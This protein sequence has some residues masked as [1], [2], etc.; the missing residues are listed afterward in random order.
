MC[1]LRATGVIPPE[2][3]GLS[4]SGT[5]IRGRGCA[6]QVHPL[7]PSA[8]LGPHTMMMPSHWEGP[9]PQSVIQMRISPRDA[10]RHSRSDALLAVWVPSA[11]A[12]RPAN[13]STAGF[14]QH[15]H[16]G[17][18]P[19]GPAP[20]VARSTHSLSFLFLLLIPGPI[21]PLARVPR[22]CLL[23]GPEHCGFSVS[24]RAWPRLPGPPLREGSWPRLHV[25]VF[26][27]WLLNPR[28]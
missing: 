22:G 14:L 18:G 15:P 23:T 4:T 20:L 19:R 5:S 7:C 9:S 28:R 11:R 13:V 26:P 3:G 10:L 12:G 16:E 1:R 17:L 27:P 6:E 8:L 25:G 21:H 24:L 2:S